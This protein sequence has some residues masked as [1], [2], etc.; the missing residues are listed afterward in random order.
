M[1]GIHY[2]PVTPAERTRHSNTPVIPNE[3]RNLQRTWLPRNVKDLSLRDD[4]P[5]RG[6]C[7]LFT[8]FQLIFF[9]FQ[10]LK[11]FRWNT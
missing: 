1:T 7:I 4:C 11:I 10:P 9:F 6:D 3:V 8:S 5:V 2:N